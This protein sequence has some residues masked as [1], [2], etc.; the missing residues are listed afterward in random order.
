MQK[1]VKKYD[2][3]DIEKLEAKEA[4]VDRELARQ[5]DK[6]QKID[7]LMQAVQQNFP[8]LYPAFQHS[9][10]PPAP[11]AA[12]PAVY[13]APS[14]PASPSTRRKEVPRES[15]PNSSRSAKGATPNGTANGSRSNR[16]NT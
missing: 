16:S 8:S 2:V 7:Q 14:T 4:A 12:R 10:R 1:L 13:S 15:T 3:P 5:A 11:V 6:A 9:V